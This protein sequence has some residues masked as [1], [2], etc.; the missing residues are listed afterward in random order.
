MIRKTLAALIIIVIWVAFQVLV[1]R[2][3]NSNNLQQE[4]DIND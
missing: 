1:D 3:S 4:V 2:Q